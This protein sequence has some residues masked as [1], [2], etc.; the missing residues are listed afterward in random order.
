MDEIEEKDPDEIDPK[1]LKAE[2]EELDEVD[3]I[4]T[5]VVDDTEVSLD[6][7]ADE[8]DEEEELLGDDE[9]DQW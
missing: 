4:P 2:E 7:M 6:K 9:E 3:V 5:D 8:E 1:I